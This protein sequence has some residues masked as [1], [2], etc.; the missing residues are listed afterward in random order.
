[1]Q[2]EG[3]S[4]EGVFLDPPRSGAGISV[5][6]ALCEISPALILYLAC[7]PVALAR[8]TKVLCGSGV[9]ELTSVAAWDAFP[10]T[11]HFESIAVFTKIKVS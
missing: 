6:E 11:H 5:C 1:M 2:K 4:P 9:Y 8:D 3:A 7:D 10:M